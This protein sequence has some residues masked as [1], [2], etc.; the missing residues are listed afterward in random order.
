MADLNALLSAE[1]GAGYQDL[2][3]TL[4]HNP[5][6]PGGDF[7]LRPL[8]GLDIL[9]VHHTVGPVSYTHLGSSRERAHHH[10]P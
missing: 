2:R 9:A 4:P 3:A 10:L 5:N 7:S 8:L 6:G 1:F